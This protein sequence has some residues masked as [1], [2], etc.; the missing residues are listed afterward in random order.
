MWMIFLIIKGYYY[1]SY[2]FILTLL[3]VFIIYNDILHSPLCLS[4]PS[5]IVSIHP[6][7]G[8]LYLVSVL[9]WLDFLRVTVNKDLLSISCLLAVWVG[10]ELG[11]NTYISIYIYKYVY[12][13]NIYV[14]R[15]LFFFFSLFLLIVLAGIYIYI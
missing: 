12:I 15:Y 11:C 13:Y 9:V 2:P 14:Y 4:Y 10:L 3:S 1:H 6:D 8:Q 7:R 5:A